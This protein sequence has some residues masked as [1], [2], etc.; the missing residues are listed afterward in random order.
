MP[1][2]ADPPQTQRR[3]P[4]KRRR[5]RRVSRTLQI[6]GV[7]GTVYGIVAGFLDNTEKIFHWYRE[8]APAS[9]APSASLQPPPNRPSAAIWTINTFDY[10]A[11]RLP[12][13]AEAVIDQIVVAAQAHPDARITIVGYADPVGSASLNQAIATSRAKVV[14]SALALKGVVADRMTVSASAQ[15]GGRYVVVTVATAVAG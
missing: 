7:I 12:A 4:Q 13:P 9:V 10:D 15:P 6:V 14:A 8:W 2:L 1:Q 11:S 3:S 5:A